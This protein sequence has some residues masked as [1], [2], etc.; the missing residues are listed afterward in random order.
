MFRWF[1]ASPGTD[2]FLPLGSLT[3]PAS[4]L[5]LSLTRALYGTNSVNFDQPQLVAGDGDPS[6]DG[7]K[8]DDNELIQ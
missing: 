7:G 5:K 4:V 1:Q 3:S 2:C 6:T 8:E